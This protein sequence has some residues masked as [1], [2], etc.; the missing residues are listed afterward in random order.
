MDGGLLSDLSV[1]TQESA[2]SGPDWL[3]RIG[4][5]IP[6]YKAE[7][8]WPHLQASLDMQGV[9]PERILVVDSSS[10]D[11]TTALARAAGYNVVTIP[12]EEFDHGGTR[13]MAASYLLQAE[14]L[15]YVTQ[16]V[17][18]A[19]P[20]SILDL[21]RTMVD[22]RVGAAYGRQ[23]PR[24]QA[25]P[26]ERHAR[27]FNYPEMSHVRSY[28]DRH[29]LGIRIAFLSNS[30]AVYRRTA[31][32][33]IGGFPAKVIFGEDTLAAARLL[34]AGWKIAYEARATVIHSHPLTVRQEFQRYFD[35]GSQH[36]RERWMLDACGRAGNEGAK[37]LRSEMQYLSQHAKRSI[38]L[39]A[40]RTAS[41]LAAYRLG[42]L[43]PKLPRALNRKL[44]THAEV[45]K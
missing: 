23:L 37:F 28:E 20:N 29:A 16:D 38:P 1:S 21:C 43:S 31:L 5:V 11:R 8:Y 35:I 24:E 9:S 17:V 30:F 18:F 45:W 3:D 12:K 39:A 42:L 19:S 7:K 41:K 15:L 40:L 44:A 14:L 27:L 34:M 26:I 10:G 25:G 36:A 33:E 22:A 13:Q 32:Q 2:A 4:I 6:T